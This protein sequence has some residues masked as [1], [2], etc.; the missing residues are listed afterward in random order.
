MP[1]ECSPVLFDFA[2]F[3]GRAMVAGFDGV[4]VTSDAGVLL[5]GATGRSIG[6]AGRFAACF[7]ALRVTERVE[8]E[9]ATRYEKRAANHV[10][11]GT[12]GMIL[13]GCGSLRRSALPDRAADE[14]AADA[15]P[16]DP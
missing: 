4:A 11:M 6:P 12:A 7:R 1:T 3:E 16:A 9:V 14:R 15:R 13:A 5:R 8:H 10:T 2:P